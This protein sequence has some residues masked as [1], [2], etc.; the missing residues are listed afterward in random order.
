MIRFKRYYPA[1]TLVVFLLLG[2]SFCREFRDGTSQIYREICRQAN[3]PVPYEYFRLDNTTNSCDIV[4]GCSVNNLITVFQCNT[5]EYFDIERQACIWSSQVDNC[6]QMRRTPKPRPLLV[7]PTPI[8]E[9]DELACGNGVCMKKEL[10]CD[11][12]FHCEDHSDEESCDLYSSPHAPAECV[13]KQD[14]QLPNCLCSNTG[15]L[16][17]ANV[18]VETIPQLVTLTLEGVESSKMTQAAKDELKKLLADMTSNPDRCPWRGT[19]FVAA[20]GE[21]DFG[22]VHVRRLATLVLGK[23]KVQNIHRPQFTYH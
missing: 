9:A 14:C 13:A 4:Y 8:C 3:S 6:A 12:I 5:G 11:G 15:T 21:S 1:V 18:Q 19:F 22:L 23:Q 20:N 10:F 16:P 7:T 17:P 2:T